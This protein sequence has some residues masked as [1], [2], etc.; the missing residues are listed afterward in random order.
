MRISWNANDLAPVPVGYFAEFQIFLEGRRLF[1]RRAQELVWADTRR[2]ADVIGPGHDAV[3]KAGWHCAAS[4]PICFTAVL[5]DQ[6]VA[7]AWARHIIAGDST[8]GCNIAYALLDQVEGRGVAKLLS[9][10]AVQALCNELPGL[11]FVNVQTRVLNTR[12]AALA[13]SF[14][15]QHVPEQEFATL[16]PGSNLM[17]QYCTYRIGMAAFISRARQVIAQRLRPVDNKFAAMEA[18]ENQAAIDCN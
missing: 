12:S 10:M 5:H 14:G 11:N 17:I 9:S 6:V 1:P 2:F 3:N 13:Q 15:M 16:R 4:A 8:H 18:T 7:A